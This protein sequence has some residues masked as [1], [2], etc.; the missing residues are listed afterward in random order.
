MPDQAKPM[1]GA[2]LG[3]V[4]CWAC[5]KACAGLGTAEGFLGLA[6]GA[7]EAGLP[8]VMELNLADCFI[9]AAAGKPLGSFLARCPRL[10]KV[11]LLRN[12]ELCTAEGLAG[13]A[14]GAGEAGLPALTELHLG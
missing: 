10:A 6:E 12:S 3:C 2:T 7:G 14:E 11:V 4:M 8:A 9:T 5:A 13:L 1:V